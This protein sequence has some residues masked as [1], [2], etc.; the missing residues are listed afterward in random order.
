[1]DET[2]ELAFTDEDIQFPNTDN[3]VLKVVKD[4]LWT[5]GIKSLDVTT[6]SGFRPLIGMLNDA[7]IFIFLF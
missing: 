6:F 1:M 7:G 4:E 5:T 3:V 2:D